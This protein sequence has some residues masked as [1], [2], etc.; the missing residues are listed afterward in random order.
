MSKWSQMYADKLT[1]PAEA[2]KDIKDGDKVWASGGSST[3]AAL[4]DALF[5]RAPELKDVKFG[6][7]IML[8]P[9]A[10]VMQPETQRNI[11]VDNYYATPLDRGFLAAGLMTHSPYNFHQLSRTAT[12]NAGYHKLLV[13]TGPMDENGYLNQGTFANFLDVIER[14]GDV[15]VQVNN[16]Q[17]RIHGQNN[18]HI[19]QVKRVVE[20]HH[21]VFAMPPAPIEETDRAIAENIIG[22]I[23]DGSTVQ[24][25]IGGTTNAIGELLM[26]KKHL[27]CHSEMINDAYMKLFEAGALDGSRKNFHRFQMNSFFALGSAE[28]YKWMDDN[29]MIYFTP[30]SYNNNPNIIG[31]ND[32]LVA[33]NTTLSIDISGQCASEAFGPIQYTATGGQVDFTKGAWISRGGKAIMVTSSTATKKDGTVVSKIVPQ[34]QAGSV[35]TLP[36]ADAMYIATE[37]GVVNLAGM[38]LRER[39]RAMIS[40]AHP[41]FRR[42]LA[43]Y[44]EEVK[45]FILPEHNPL[46]G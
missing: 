19:S 15:Y 25:G 41:D 11:L 17:P 33:I 1:T 7:Y 23:E 9:T 37:Y 3:P 6:S 27:G 16:E 28:L 26:E 46:N 35:V 44:A 21:P 29:P 39:A 2:M 34:L 4:M 36:R 40:L 32:N 31:K 24:L 13:Q 38:D 18:L 45:Y 30:I 12:A 14:L 22:L 20:S 43:D 10:K 5:D 42:E 8:A